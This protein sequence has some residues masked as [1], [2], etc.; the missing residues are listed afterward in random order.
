MYTSIPVVGATWGSGQGSSFSL[1]CALVYRS[2]TDTVTSP[3][4]RVTT[5]LLESRREQ[6]PS[7]HG[8]YVKRRQPGQ[9][10]SEAKTN[11][12]PTKIHSRLHIAQLLNFPRFFSVHAAALVTLCAQCHT[13]ST[14]STQPFGMRMLCPRR[15]GGI[16][17]SCASRSPY[18]NYTFTRSL[19]TLSTVAKFLLEVRA[20]SVQVPP[21]VTHTRERMKRKR[22]C[23]LG[24]ADNRLI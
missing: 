12:H 11:P 23:E 19:A 3:N 21:A 15:H 9:G 22:S 13:R 7:K 24:S 14:R 4:S 20:L 10:K 5:Q 17:D 16:A 2:W 1:S 8:T 18:W 6:K